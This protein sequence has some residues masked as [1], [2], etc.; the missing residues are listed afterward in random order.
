MPAATPALELQGLSKRFGG[1]RAL[2]DV[3]LTVLPGEIHGLLGENGSG[4]STLIKVL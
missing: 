1:S 2:I 4:K 3:D